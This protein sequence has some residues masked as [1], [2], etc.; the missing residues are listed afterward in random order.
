MKQE[1]KSDA[2]YNV[3]EDFSAFLEHSMQ[4]E[5]EELFLKHNPNRTIRRLLDVGCASGRTSVFTLRHGVEELVGIELDPRGAQIAA[6][7]MSRVVQADA[8]S[9][10]LDYPQ[11][12]FDALFFTDI[13]EHLVDP[14]ATLQRYTR[15]LRPGGEVLVVLPNAGHMAIFLNLMIGRHEYEESGLMDR[16]HLRF[17]VQNTAVQLITGAGLE[18]VDLSYRLDTDWNLYRDNTRIQTFGGAITI[19]V[20]PQRVPESLRKTWFARKLHFWARKPA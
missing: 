5:V 11:G 1:D 16:G 17:F 9:V 6:Q 8:S 20:D 3:G 10:E 15:W 7:H 2:Y 4:P 18:V 12:Y 19:E 13:L 14:W